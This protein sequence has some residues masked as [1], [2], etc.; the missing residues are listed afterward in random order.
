MTG[1]IRLFVA[2]ALEAGGELPATP[3]QA[4]YLGHV[5]RQAAGAPVVLFN[6]RDGEFQAELAAIRRD[7]AS[8]RVGAMLRPQVAEPDL[9]LVFAPLK[10]DATD[11]V[12]EKATEL[13]VSRIRPVF[14][15]RTNT[16]RLNL[17][18]LSAIAREAAEQCERLTVPR[19]DPA[20][21]L[22]D[23]LGAWPTDR[24]LSAAIERGGAAIPRP[25][26]GAAALLIGPE[27]GFTPAELDALRRLPFVQVIG[28]GPRILRAETAA[29]VG[30]ALLQA[31]STG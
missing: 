25:A 27:G 3:E 11:L 12:I 16:A 15:A 22:F 19:I 4:H 18:R 30:L 8:F 7:R 29:I 23:L 1:S 10:R 26:E 24:V 14:T 6:G 5:M 2:A 9:T 28:L 13:G 17:D 20:V 31:G 21:S